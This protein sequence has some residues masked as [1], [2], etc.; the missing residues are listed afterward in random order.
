MEIWAYL[1]NIPQMRD[2]SS[3]VTKEA[4]GPDHYR[5]ANTWS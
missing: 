3:L 1:N 5:L 4:Q 2:F